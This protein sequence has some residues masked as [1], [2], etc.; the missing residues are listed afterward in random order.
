MYMDNS[1]FV[2]TQSTDENGNKTVIGGGYKINSFFLNSGEPIMNTNLFVHDNDDEQHGGKKT[3]SFENLA[4]PAGLY[5]VDQKVPKIKA[6]THYDDDHKMLP[7]D[8]YEKLLLLVSKDH[9]PK[10]RTT[11]R[12]NISKVG[13][14]RHT[15]RAK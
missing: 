1:D 5:Y 4:V 6:N 2:F 8:I 13:S 14:K 10:K 9:K 7:E 15:K 12:N 3:T 11:R